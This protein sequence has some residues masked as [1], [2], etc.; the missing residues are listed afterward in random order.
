MLKTNDQM[1]EWQ[2][3]A[4][5]LPTATPPFQ[6]QPGHLD[7]QQLLQL[8]PAHYPV[9]QILRQHDVV[10]AGAWVELEPTLRQ[11]ASSLAQSSDRPSTSQGKML[12]PLVCPIQIL[13]TYC[14]MHAQDCVVFALWLP[15]GMPM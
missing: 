15:V 1:D 3:W 6:I 8:T 11:L 14:F 7:F 5:G 12:Q 13:Y 10:N 2:V 9:L 4:A